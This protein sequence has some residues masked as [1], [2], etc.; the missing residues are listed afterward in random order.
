L[1]PVAWLT[2]PPSVPELHDVRAVVD[3]RVLTAG[4]E[5]LTDDR[6]EVVDVVRAELATVEHR[7]VAHDAAAVG[8]RAAH[9]SP[10]AEPNTRP[11]R[12]S[13]R[14]ARTF[15]RASGSTALPA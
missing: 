3:E 12:R 10:T 2:P 9:A 13:R 14:P 6:T 7:D 4:K 15:R 5:D 8:E 1:T 11:H